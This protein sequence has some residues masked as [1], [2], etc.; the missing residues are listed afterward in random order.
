MRTLHVL[1]VTMNAFISM[2]SYVRFYYYFGFVG[3]VIV[4][5]GLFDERVAVL[6]EI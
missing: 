1:A 2:Q 3:I 5:D 6:E 4:A